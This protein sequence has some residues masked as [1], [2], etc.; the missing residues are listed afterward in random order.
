VEEDTGNNGMS[1]HCM[2]IME[3]QRMVCERGR[4]MKTK[5]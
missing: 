5:I 4:K 1:E 3:K 2:V